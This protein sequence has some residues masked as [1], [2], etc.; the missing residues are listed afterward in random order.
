MPCK[1]A[2]IRGCVGVSPHRTGVTGSGTT[3]GCQSSDKGSAGYMHEDPN[4][5]PTLGDLDLPRLDL[6]VA[7]DDGDQPSQRTEGQR[8]E[9]SARSGASTDPRDPGV[10][11]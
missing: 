2:R 3:R 11:R 4:P 9:G 5:V 10:P 6:A 7:A 8:D 1:L